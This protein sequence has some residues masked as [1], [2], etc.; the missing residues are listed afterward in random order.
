MEVPKKVEFYTLSH[1]TVH[2]QDDKEVQLNDEGIAPSSNLASAD[3][4]VSDDDI[5]SDNLSFTG[6]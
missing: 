3:D 1:D 2:H 4:V 5:E 6:V